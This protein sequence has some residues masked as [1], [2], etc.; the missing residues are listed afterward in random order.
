[1]IAAYTAPDLASHSAA[2][3]TYDTRRSAF[4]RRPA[5][6]P[7]A[8]QP[9]IAPA[10]QTANAPMETLPLAEAQTVLSIGRDGWVA[11]TT[12]AVAIILLAI[13]LVV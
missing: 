6:L 12:V 13:A 10:T 8:F 7:P 5:D 11:W 1:M 9:L 4:R 3:T 2:L